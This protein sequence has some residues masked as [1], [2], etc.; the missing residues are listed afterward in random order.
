MEG[1]FSTKSDVYSFGVLLLEIVTGIRRSSSSETKG[2]P[3]LIVYVSTHKISLEFQIYK[4]IRYSSFSQQ[5]K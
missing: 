3:S 2:F 4:Y 1:V 5:P